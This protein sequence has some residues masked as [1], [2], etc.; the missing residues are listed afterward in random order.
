MV[1][2]DLRYDMEEHLWGFSSY[3][4]WKTRKQYSL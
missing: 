2:S 4:P 1:D 3:D